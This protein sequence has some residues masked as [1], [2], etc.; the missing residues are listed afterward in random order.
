MRIF[1]WLW[2]FINGEPYNKPVSM[3]TEYGCISIR[4]YSCGGDLCHKHCILWHTEEDN[5]GRT[6]FL[7][8]P[9]ANKYGPEKLKL[10]K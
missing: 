7:C 6:I 10:V 4:S 9:T 3:C 2:T 1:N 8:N 5:N